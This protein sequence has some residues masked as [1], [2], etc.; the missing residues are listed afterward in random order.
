MAVVAWIF[1][2]LLSLVWVRRLHSSTTIRRAFRWAQAHAHASLSAGA[3]SLVVNGFGYVPAFIFLALGDPKW[4]A[5]YVVA[6]S[7]LGLQV[8]MVASFR[9]LLFR[10]FA[11]SRGH[12]TWQSIARVC[13]AM[14][15]LSIFISLASIIALAV[16]GKSIYGAAASIALTMTIWIAVRQAFGSSSIVLLGVLRA[17]GGWSKGLL[18]EVLT[19]IALLV[20]MV[21]AGL[22]LGVA[23]VTPAQALGAGVSLGI[24]TILLRSTRAPGMNESPHED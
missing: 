18:G 23:W 17:R 14:S 20:F 24:W 9:P 6:N 8:A 13:A 11:E 5:G 7:V 10:R 16:I 3:Q 15:G 21:I 22:T 12:E 2:A 1:G 4:S 19:A